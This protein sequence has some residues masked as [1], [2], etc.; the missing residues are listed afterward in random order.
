MATTFLRWRAFVFAIVLV[1]PI[2]SAG[3]DQITLTAAEEKDSYEIYSFLLRKEMPQQWNISAWAISQ[4]TR[5][6]PFD[7]EPNGRSPAAC[8]EPS[9]DQKSIYLPLI[10]DY[11]AKNKNK[12]ILKPKFD[13]PK[14]A[15]VD[16]VVTKAI[17]ERRIRSASGVSANSGD[18][19]KLVFPLN[20]VVIF[21]VS[22]V[23]FNADRTRA[24]VYVGHNCGGLCGGGTYHLLVKKDGHWQIDRWYRGG[25]CV[26]AS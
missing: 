20:A 7:G 4:E 3:A 1:L 22:A 8:L 18:A 19:A 21:D 11:V 5:T 23:G 9:P 25:G 26:W 17:Q 24:L 2:V 12:L 14:F 16:D 15:L 13:L 10:E 6:F